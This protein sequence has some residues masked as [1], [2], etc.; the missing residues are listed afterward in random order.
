MLYKLT[1]GL[2]FADIDDLEGVVLHPRTLATFAF[3]ETGVWLFKAAQQ[4]DGLMDTR[5]LSKEMSQEFE[6]SYEQA[7]SDVSLFCQT[8]A[9]RGLAKEIPQEGAQ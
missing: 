2:N 3:N 7:L 1:Q 8:L 5:R 4:A 9:D 6:V